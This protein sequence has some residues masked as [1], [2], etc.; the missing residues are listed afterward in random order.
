MAIN[1]SRLERFGDAYRAQL[2][3]R[4]AARPDDEFTGGTRADFADLGRAMMLNQIRRN[5]GSMLRI[6]ITAKEVKAAGRL[7]GVNP[8]THEGWHAFF[9]GEG[10]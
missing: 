8:Q 9:T 6:S 2:I 10:A 3:E 1:E 7:V 5:G 4:Y